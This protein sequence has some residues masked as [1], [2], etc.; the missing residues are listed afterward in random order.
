MPKK[1]FVHPERDAT[2][3]LRV[4]CAPNGELPV[5]ADCDKDRAATFQAYQQKNLHRIEGHKAPNK[6]RN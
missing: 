3:I 1:C 5:C 6:E 4:P 2:N